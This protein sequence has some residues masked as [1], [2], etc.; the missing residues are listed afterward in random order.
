VGSG[1]FG[2]GV[3][4]AGYGAFVVVMFL[5]LENV[6]TKIK[7]AAAVTKAKNATIEKATPTLTSRQV[8]A[9]KAVATRKARAELEAAY[10]LPSAPV[11]GA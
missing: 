8:A 11:S 4:P 2:G 7:P 9:R 5:V 1:W 6:G 10:R 3:G